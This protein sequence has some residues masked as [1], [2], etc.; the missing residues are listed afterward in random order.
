MHSRLLWWL[1]NIARVVPTASEVAFLGA[2]LMGRKFPHPW[3]APYSAFGFPKWK[4]PLP[5]YFPPGT[6]ALGGYWGMLG[7]YKNHIFE[8]ICSNMF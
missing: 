8:G 3:D 5:H 1:P 2:F 4:V 7:G 6:N